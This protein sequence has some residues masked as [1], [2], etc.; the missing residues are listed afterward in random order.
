MQ[1]PVFQP[2]TFTPRV[3]TG[4]R[5]TLAEVRQVVEAPAGQAGAQVVDARPARRFVAGHLG[6]ATNLYWMET[7]K[8]EEHPTFL[9]PDQLRALLAARG[10]QPGR[11]VVTY[12]EVG[13]QAS[14]SYFLFKY[15]GYDAAMFDGSYQEWSTAKLPVVTGEAK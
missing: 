13:L 1:V 2:T 14:H 15:L 10:L 5:A 8:S 11:K 6:G 4:V 7:L 3:K 12:C 9:P